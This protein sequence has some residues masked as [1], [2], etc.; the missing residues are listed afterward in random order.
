MTNNFY[1]YTESGLDNVY[2][3]GGVLHAEGRLVI[4]DIDG[5]HRVIGNALISSKKNLAGRE[6]RF[7]RQEMSMS[8]ST[9]A[10]LLEVSEQAVARWEKGKSGL[11]KPAEALIRLLYREFIGEAGK[12][13]GIREKLERIAELEDEIDGDKVTVKKRNGGWQVA[14]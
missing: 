2:L 3:D 9:L 8:Q 4:K 10:K 11:P 14:A 13:T 12:K 6:V 5:L 1:H 7:L